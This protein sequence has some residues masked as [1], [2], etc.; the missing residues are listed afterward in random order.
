MLLKTKYLIS[1]D[2]FVDGNVIH[3]NAVCV[4]TTPPPKMPS[5]RGHDALSP[6]TPS[7]NIMA[8]EYNIRVSSEIERGA[9]TNRL[10]VRG[11]QTRKHQLQDGKR[12][13]ATHQQIAIVYRTRV[14]HFVIALDV[15]QPP[16]HPGS[17]HH[18]P[19]VSILQRF[20]SR[21]DARGT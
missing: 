11:T 2:K 9:A 17:L 5:L 3:S 20:F 18:K 12:H 1:N 15:S 21:N 7:S 14:L 8:H 6:T 16:M 13:F 4:R 19:R 10:A